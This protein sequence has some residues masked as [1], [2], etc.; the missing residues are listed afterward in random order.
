MTR[1]RAAGTAAPCG[2]ATVPWTV[3]ARATVATIKLERKKRET[4]NGRERIT[5]LLLGV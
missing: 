4:L 3:A 5:G 2:S 1:T